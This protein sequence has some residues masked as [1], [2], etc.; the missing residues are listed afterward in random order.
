[1]LQRSAQ[2]VEVSQSAAEYRYS[3][4]RLESGPGYQNT[5][6]CPLGVVGDG[7]LDLDAESLQLELKAYVPRRDLPLKTEALSLRKEAGRPEPSAAVKKAALRMGNAVELSRGRIG[8]PPHRGPA[9]QDVDRA[10]V[11]KGQLSRRR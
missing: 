2:G 8:H 1:M 5:C 11:T 10:R 6:S 3:S 9:R 7:V 4:C